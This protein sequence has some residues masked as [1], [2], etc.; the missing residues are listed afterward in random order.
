[1]SAVHPASGPGRR[2]SVTGLG[3]VGLPVAIA[4]AAAA[5]DG[6]PVIGYDI[7]GGRIAELDRGVDRTG[8][9][10]SADIRRALAAGRIRFT[11]DAAGLAEADFH[12]V[13]A[14]T[15]IT[16]ARVPDLGSLSAATR[17]VGG[18]LRRGAIVCFES[19]VYP[20][21]TEEV[22]RPILE[23]AS[24]LVAGRDF[25]VAYSPE[26]INPGDRTH[27]FETITKVVAA[28]D[29]ATLDVVARVYAGVVT[30]GIYRAA[31][32]RT[33][34]AAK[35]L[36]NTQRDLNIALMNELAMISARLG[37]DTGEVLAAARSKWNFL[38][39]SPGLVGGHCVGVDPY[40]L[41]YAAERAGHHPDV[42]LA[43]RR[44]N[45]GMA[46]WLAEQTV[47]RLLSAGAAGPFTVAVLGLAFKEDVPD[48][49]NSRVAPL[50]RALE[51]FGARV[52]VHDPL[53][54]PTDAQA[55]HGI[56]LRP[57]AELGPA[58]AVILAVPH[59][60][61]VKGGWPLVATPFAGRGGLVVDVRGRLDADRCPP[62]LRLWRP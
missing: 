60:A 30:A 18:A 14:P 10:A 2:I 35:I 4:F 9:V 56:P 51:G 44:I 62:T 61:Y 41:T 23:A 46:A 36:E 58:D 20:G 38:D 32:I 40:Y 48:V 57:L 17:A 26:R 12:I 1:M 34:E 33:A 37:L 47:R 11:T 29:A 16:E 22:C 25:A 21:A 7:D 24:G 43:G 45:D 19:T 15:P 54:D 52:G 8:E 28:A 39:F 6:A 42:I 3:Y 53:V 50:V 49:R 59:R 5:D 27:R 55:R 13:A 31:S